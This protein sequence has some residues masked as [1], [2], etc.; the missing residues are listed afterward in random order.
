MNEQPRRPGRSLGRGA[1]QARPERCRSP[2]CA[3]RRT[4]ATPSRSSSR[5][6]EYARRYAALR[7]KMREHKLDAVI[8]PGG[9][10]HWSF[11]GGMT[12]LTGHWEWHAL[13]L[14]RAGA[15]RRR[16]DHDLLDGRHPRRSGAPAGRRSRSRTCATAATAVRRGDGRAAARTEARARPHR[17]DGDRP[18]PRRLHAGQPVQR[19]CA[20]ACPTPRSCSP[21]SFLHDLVVIHCEEELDCVRKAG[22]LCQHAM[23]AM[24]AR[25]EA[26]REGD[27]SCAPP[28]AAPSWTAAAT[29]TSSSSARRRW[30]IRR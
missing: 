15:A 25:G 1:R 19:R 10:S 12:W 4:T 13:V 16:A 17:P 28:P 8:V 5:Q 3:T 30:T 26:R 21:R 20:R 6:A 18:A 9:P 22:V 29:S 27:T 2:T 7:A 14:L 24:V 23:E 11:G